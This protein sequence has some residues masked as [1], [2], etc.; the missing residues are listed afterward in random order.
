VVAFD[1]AIRNGYGGLRSRCYLSEMRLPVEEAIER[2]SAQ[3]YLFGQCGREGPR[4]GT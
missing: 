4:C 2:A 3:G 1:R